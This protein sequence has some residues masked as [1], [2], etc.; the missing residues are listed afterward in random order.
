M[1]EDGRVLR[2]GC[3][4]VSIGEQDLRVMMVGCMRAILDV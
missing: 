2:K 1:D 4:R 3:G